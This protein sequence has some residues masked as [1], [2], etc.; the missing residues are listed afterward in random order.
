MAF[1]WGGGGGMNLCKDILPVFPGGKPGLRFSLD[2]PKSRLS[3]GAAVLRRVEK[4][5]ENVYN[6]L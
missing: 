6:R 4:Y 3:T 2:L 1:L 5:V